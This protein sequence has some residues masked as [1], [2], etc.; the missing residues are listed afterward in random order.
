VLRK[1]NRDTRSVAVGLWGILVLVAWADVVLTQKR[2]PPKGGLTKITSQAKS[3][4]SP[5]AGTATRFTRTELSANRSSGA[6]TSIDSPLPDQ[7]PAE[8]SPKETVGWTQIAVGSTPSPVLVLSPEISP[9]SA[10]PNRSE[11]LLPYKPNSVRT[12]RRRA[13][14]GSHWSA[15]QLED[16]E[17]KRRLLAL[18]HR[19]LAK[20][21]IFEAG[22]TKESRQHHPEKGTLMP[23]RNWFWH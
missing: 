11:S 10:E 1:F 20:S 23:K 22:Q 21:D 6:V 7:T 15:R 13:P 19:S 9:P 3:D 8:H 2:H 17:A 12:S 4:S 16:A 5:T 18:W 14:Y